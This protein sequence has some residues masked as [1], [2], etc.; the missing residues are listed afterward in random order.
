MSRY[1]MPVINNELEIHRTSLVCEDLEDGSV[2]TFLVLSHPRLTQNLDIS[3]NID[4]QVFLVEW[5]SVFKFLVQ[6]FAKVNN[7]H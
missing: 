1:K 6:S 2:L 3:L 7:G 5:N 4:V